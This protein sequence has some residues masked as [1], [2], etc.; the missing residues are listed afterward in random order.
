MAFNGFGLSPASGAAANES[1]GAAANSL[2]DEFFFV[3]HTYDH[4][5]LDCYQ[6]V[7]NSRVCTPANYAQSYDEIAQNLDSVKGLTLPIDLES[8]VTPGISALANT[9]FLKAAANQGVKY[10]VTD[11]SRAGWRPS[12]P[13]TGVFSPYV[14]S[15]LY[16]PRRATNIFYNTN[17]GSSGITGSLV[18]EYNLFYGANGLF[19]APGG[20]PYFT[21]DQTYADIIN[22]E[23][24][25]LLQYM[26]RGEIDPT[27]YHQANMI[28]CWGG[29]TL[30]LDVLDAASNKYMRVAGSS[31]AQHH[32]VRN[33]Q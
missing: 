24:D 10:L 14:P 25:Q 30:I 2:R 19:R 3:N 29:N 32:A 28:R 9:N 8:M 12:Q 22:R 17:S 16:I 31:R 4:E 7:P 6:P 33:R 18:D 5:N 20:V 26:L 1:L 13:N 11:M 21:A 27:M 23:S 15:I